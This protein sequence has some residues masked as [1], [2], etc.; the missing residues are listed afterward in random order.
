MSAP[1]GY[2]WFRQAGGV[3]PQLSTTISGR[4]LSFVER[5][6]ITLLR[7]QG[8]SVRAIGRQLGRDAATISWE[9]RRN[10]STRT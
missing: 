8:L 7:A 4:Y 5:E 9:L 10:A 6:D 3:K 1:V 2:R